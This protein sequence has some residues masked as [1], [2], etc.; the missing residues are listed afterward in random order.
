MHLTIV[1]LTKGRKEYLKKAL[2]SYQ[3]FIDTGNVN[4]VLIDNGADAESSEILLNWKEL[5]GNKVRYFRFEVN[6]EAGFSSFWETIESVNA[7]WIINPGDDDLLV[8][9]AYLEW[10][11][12]LNKNSKLN[13]FASSARI[14]DSSGKHTG[15]FKSPSIY[16]IKDSLEL[17]ARSLSEPPFFWPALYFRFSTIQKPMLISRFVHD[18]WIDLQLILQ[19]EISSTEKIGIDYRVHDRQESFQTSSRRKYFEAA[20]MIIDVMN[21]STFKSVIEGF[22]DAEHEKFL[23]LCTSFKPV[24]SDPGYYFSIIKTIA[25]NAFVYIKLPINKTRYAEKFAS[26]AGVYL[27][28]NDIDSIFTGFYLKSTSSSP[29]NLDINFKPGVCDNLLNIKKDF[30]KDASF[31]IIISCKHSGKLIESVYVDCENFDLLTR[32]EISDKVL[33]TIIEFLE[34][35]GMLASSLSPN[36][37]LV[38]RYIRRLKPRIPF[39]FAPILLKFKKILSP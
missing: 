10:I 24:Y 39:F 38:L 19:G 34:N 35:N 20:N 11:K 17:I 3:P 29:G 7:D 4:V 2:D 5:Q 33:T 13:A 18:W 37:R 9:D 22:S 15:Q 6:N 14:I 31:K 16:G 23:E 12:A 8:F 36:E 26:S 25:T 32:S 21:S 28:K 1:L 30:N 27:K